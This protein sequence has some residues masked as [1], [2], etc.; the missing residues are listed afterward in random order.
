MPYG[1]STARNKGT[2]N[3]LLTI[4]RNVI[5]EMVLA[6]L[7]DQLM[8]PEAY[9]EF[10]AEFNREANRLDSSEDQERGQCQS[11]LA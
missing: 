3:N 8:Q 2:C 7:K 11:K 5:V 9:E 10:I 4:R 6:G 1:C